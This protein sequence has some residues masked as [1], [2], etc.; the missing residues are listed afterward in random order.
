MSNVDIFESFAA[1]FEDAVAD[2]HW[3]RLEKYFAVDATYL[4]LGGPD[5][6]C[7]SRD[8]ILTYFKQDVTNTDR[9]FDTRTLV[10]VSPPLID[11]EHLSRRWRCTYTLIGAPDV[12]LEGESR[13]LFERGL[14]K[15]LEVELTES[16]M[17]ILVDWMC[18]NG[19][20]L[21]K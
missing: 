9:K 2:D 16:S 10:A 12:I 5:P 8:A 13:Y 1:D 20:K 21:Q 6:K 11:G 17:Q 18:E 19:D 7:V 3:L 14:I 4:N 15:A